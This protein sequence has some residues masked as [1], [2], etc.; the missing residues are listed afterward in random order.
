MQDLTAGLTRTGEIIGTAKYL[1]PEQV[2]GEAPGPATDLYATAAV[3]F[4]ALAGRPPFTADTPVALVLAHRDQAPPPLASLVVGVHPTVAAV[5]DRALAKDPSDRPVSA[6]AMA[7]ALRELAP[8][9]TGT[10]VLAGPAPAGGSSRPA[11]RSRRGVIVIATVVGG[12]LGF[13]VIALAYRSGS[14]DG[15][16]AVRTD[17][18]GEEAASTLST[19]STTTTVPATTGVPPTTPT[20]LLSVGTVTDLLSAGP[21]EYGKKGPDLLDKL[22]EV[23]R[24][25]GRD[26]AEKAADLIEDIDDW[27]E[28]GELDPAIAERARQVLVPIADRGEGDSDR[29]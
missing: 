24:E 12:L 17:P 14:D 28:D 27:V 11:P 2:R 3:L 8:T 5:V 15:R 21:E 18:T 7:T 20:T 9:V 26:Q 1:A 29:D 10:A 16:A 19:P 23:Q 6:A 25:R 13:A 22:Q 4:E